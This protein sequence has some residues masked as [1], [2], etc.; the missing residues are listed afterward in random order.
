MSSNIDLFDSYYMTGSLKA[1]VPKK[2]FFRDRYFPTGTGDLFKANK[3]L[4]EY[5]DGDEKIAPFVVPR[6]RDIA[7]ERK[8]YEVH[9]IEAPYIGISRMLTLDDLKKR[10]FGEAILTNTTEAERART[11]QMR[12]LDELSARIGRREE[13]LAAQ[14]IINNG[15]AITSYIDNLTVGETRNIYYYDTAG[16]NPAVYTVG[17]EWD[18]TNGDF[19]GDVEAMCLELAQRGLPATDLILGSTAARA[20][21]AMTEVRDLLNKT[22][23]IITGE[24]DAELTQYPGVAFLGTLNFNGYRLNLFSANHTYVA[25]NGTRTAFFPAKSAAVIA[26][27][28]GHM[29]YA[30]I[31]QM[32]R[33]EEYETF[34][35]KR[36]AKLVV[37]Q[38]NDS[39]KLRVAAR[40]LAAPRFKAPWM[41]AANAVK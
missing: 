16:S 23:G 4:V 14:T 25:D 26:P 8:G 24:I 17:D 5:M 27:D 39:R 36:V 29:M 3:V 28:C 12:D 22:S 32:N 6:A 7:V 40:P 1:M 38:N 13:W 31:T 2:S 18:D 11:L 33:N 35:E 30:E 41:Y 9:E 34:A 15:C 20:V 19:F 37:D 21:L 10:G